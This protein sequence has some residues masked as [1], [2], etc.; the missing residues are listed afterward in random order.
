MSAAYATTGTEP[1]SLTPTNLTEKDPLI[2]PTITLLLDMCDPENPVLRVPA[3]YRR[4]VATFGSSL[5]ITFQV[6]VV[7]GVTVTFDTP[8][9]TFAQDAVNG[10]VIPTYDVDPTSTS[11]KMAWTNATN[12]SS[13]PNG[14]SFYYTLHAIVTDN[15]TNRILP[16]SH[17]PT[18]HN[19]PPG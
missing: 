3:Q 16:V 1:V 17:D 7:E 14:T 15:I 18:V 12:R 10:S 9:I 2:I 19:D 5:D 8:A 11:L 4:L 6:P 13:F